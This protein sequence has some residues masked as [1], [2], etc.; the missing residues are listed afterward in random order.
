LNWLLSALS[1]LRVVVALAVQA[2]SPSRSTC[3]KVSLS[4]E[5]KSCAKILVLLVVCRLEH[6]LHEFDAVVFKL[7]EYK[8]P[9]VVKLH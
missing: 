3:E 5:M 2:T 1:E 7:A 4:D 8:S 9:I 6:V